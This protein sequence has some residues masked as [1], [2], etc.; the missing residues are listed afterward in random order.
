MSCNLTETS[1]TRPERVK[2][3]D[4]IL[5][6]SQDSIIVTGDLGRIAAFDAA[7]KRTLGLNAGS[8]AAPHHG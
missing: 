1:S 5:S 8:D 3:A 6:S 7:A 2:L 4:A